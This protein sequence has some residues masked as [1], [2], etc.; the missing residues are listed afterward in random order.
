[1]TN[2][3]INSS[4]P[5]LLQHADNPV[6]WFQWN[7]EALKKSKTED[8]PIFLSIGY[9]ACHWCHVMAHE[10]FED[11]DIAEIMNKFFVNIKVDREERPDLDSIYMDAVVALTGHGGWP[12]SVFLTPD[13]QAFYG[14][15]YFPPVPR[16]NMP[17]FREILLGVARAWKEDR[18]RLLEAGN[19]VTNHIKRNQ[20]IPGQTSQLDAK[21]LDRAAETLIRTYDWKYGGWGSAPKFPQHMAIEFLLRR[22]SR[23]NKGSLDVATHALRS[24]AQGGMYDLVGG[25]FARY[26]TDN[27]WLVPHFEKMLY[28]NAL[29][30][31]AYLHAYL[32]TGEPFYRRI[33][34][35]TLDFVMRE[36]TDPLGGFYSSLDADSEGEEGKFYIWTEAEIRTALP[37]DEDADIVLAAYGFSEQGNFDGKTIPRRL[38]EDSQIADRFNLQVDEVPDLLQRINQKL[39]AVREKCIRPGID[40]KVIVA[41][42]GWMCLAFSEAARYLGFSVYKE[43]ATRNLSFL[44]EYMLIEG[45]LS[46]SWRSGQAN[47]T[48]YLDDHASLILALIDLYN[49]V[50]DPKWFQ[51]ALELSRIMLDRFT[52]EEELFFDTPIDHEHLL[53]RPR[54]IQDNA[55]PSGNALAASALLQL[56][57][58]QGDGNLRDLA[59]NML[60]RLQDSA[61]KYPTA[62]SWWLCAM[63]LA[64]H[65]IREIAIIGDTEDTRTKSFLDNLWSSYRPDVISATSGLP[66]PD[67]APNLLEN[68]GMLNNS[69]TAYICEGFF[70]KQ[71]VNDIAGF[72]NQLQG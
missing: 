24:M 11:P 68:R 34:Q 14:G 58:Y 9:A 51:S 29:L 2:D 43:V 65:P 22:A 39:L 6:E 40:D 4:S 21:F 23:G 70:C 31:R 46:R 67:N 44:L 26:S 63:D 47:H 3:L 49:T 61:V 59:E 28:D 10:S 55:T 69:P 45:R 8:K 25:G 48:G 18:H 13:L 52:S 53:I 64:L 56:S 7:D 19:Q 1:M 37:D 32:I 62:F 5:Y 50:P 33:C 20:L 36:M 57:A 54:D 35:E 17:A 15:T 30:S 42:N 41:W 12:M 16:Y 66:I 27:E 60:G 38:L 71:P 72:N